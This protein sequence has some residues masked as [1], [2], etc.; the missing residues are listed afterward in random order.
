M[1]SFVESKLAPTPLAQLY[2]YVPSSIANL[3]VMMTVFMTLVGLA[4]A[5]SQKVRDVLVFSYTCFLQPLGK[6]S[7]QAERLDRFYQ[8]QATGE[9]YPIRALR[10]RPRRVRI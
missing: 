3:T 7:T 9:F 2:S 8:N 5:V 4:A 1:S 10:L 6:T